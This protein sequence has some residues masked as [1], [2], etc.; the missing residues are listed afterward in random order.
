MEDLIK[1]LDLVNQPRGLSGGDY[2]NI[3]NQSYELFLS[4]SE[5]D[6][7][8]VTYRT[9]T[10]LFFAIKMYGNYVRILS[11]K[12]LGD[13]YNGKTISEHQQNL[14]EKINQLDV[15]LQAL[16]QE[17]SNCIELIRSKYASMRISGIESTE[18]GFEEFLAKIGIK[19][20]EIMTGPGL[21]E[22]MIRQLV[23]E[24]I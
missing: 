5:V 8:L 10:C 1:K 4:S 3:L 23:M 18:T 19:D 20:V 11:N 6:D 15:Q 13:E 2:F 21:T 12:K 9:F 7:S 14:I 16:N 24:E 22:K 17:S